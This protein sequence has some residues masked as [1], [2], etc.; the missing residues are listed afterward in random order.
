MSKS[1]W[2]TQRK[3][4]REVGV[5]GRQLATKG[6]DEPVPRTAGHHAAFRAPLV[7]PERYREDAQNPRPRADPVRSDPISPEEFDGRQPLLGL[8]PLA[9]DL[10]LAVAGG[11]AR[12][13]EGGRANPLTRRILIVT[14]GH[15]SFGGGVSQP[16]LCR[17][18]ISSPDAPERRQRDANKKG[19]S[20][21]HENLLLWVQPSAA[22]HHALRGGRDKLSVRDEEILDRAAGP[23]SGGKPFWL[24]AST[25]P[26]LVRKV[27]VAIFRV[28]SRI[29]TLRA[30]RP[31]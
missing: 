28:N 6:P 7:T 25:R 12:C 21:S 15:A 20:D 13:A 31:L 29:W 9:T 14:T 27:G 4:F 3:K 10:S 8:A 2:L 11:N 24:F 1:S 23:Q 16:Q 22:T 30:R 5:E 17:A 18:E 19:Q 26:R